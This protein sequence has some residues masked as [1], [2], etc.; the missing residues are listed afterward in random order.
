MEVVK[1]PRDIRKELSVLIDVSGVNPFDKLVGPACTYKS[2]LVA[3]AFSILPICPNR[4]L[5]PKPL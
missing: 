3:A 5:S 1:A 4:L 2:S